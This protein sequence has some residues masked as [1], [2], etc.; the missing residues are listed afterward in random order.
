[1][2]A[3]AVVFAGLQQQQ[4]NASH[5]AALAA[6]ADGFLTEHARMRYWREREA[7]NEYLLRGRPT[8]LVEVAAQERA[9]D[10]ALRQFNV[11][12]PQERRSI[13]KAKAANDTFVTEFRNDSYTQTNTGQ[14]ARAID[15]MDRQASRVLA[16][17]Q[18]LL[19]TNAAEVK[20]Y[21]RRG[22]RENARVRLL[23]AAAVLL[24][25]LT[26]GYFL[27]A[28]IRLYRR[29]TQQNR[30]LKELD[31]LKDDFVASVSHEFR[32]PLTSIRG[33]AELLL[34]PETGPLND[35]QRRFLGT[36]NRSSERLLRLVGDLLFIAQLDATSLCLQPAPLSL[37]QIVE[38]AV[39]AARPAAEAKSLLITTEITDQPEL[40][41]DEARLGQ[42]LDN[43]ITN[44][45]KFTQ[46]GTVT[47]TLRTHE[48]HAEIEIRDTGIGIPTAEQ[49]RL[50]ERFF[51]SSTAN[52]YAIQGS[53]LG[54]SIAKA[55]VQGHG[56]TID[57]ASTEG[58]GTT[59]RIRLPLPTPSQITPREPA[60][61]A[62]HA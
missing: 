50:F 14:S 18:A 9:F 37:S 25:L 27:A 19:T 49:Q 47:V 57:L 32:T 60:E 17:L 43:L 41:G 13:S 24:F 5:A 39:D 55:I 31:A 26:L 12:G 22:A 28:A 59:F 29:N 51:R 34:D 48:R 52:A 10:R 42:L 44:A 7:V 62:P 30:E 4:A 21:V 38:D 2:I 16:P 23:A 45:I 11:S 40:I 58:Q 3:G 61:L 1:L 54:L 6:H 20:L 53:G 56:G 33:Y 15:S 36:M 46:T 8:L 35:D